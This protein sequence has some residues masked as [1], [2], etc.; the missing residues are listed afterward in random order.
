MWGSRRVRHMQCSGAAINVRVA[1]RWRRSVQIV[2]LVLQAAA[3]EWELR[4][5][6]R[7]L[8][9]P[10]RAHVYVQR[11]ADRHASLS[12]VQELCA[13]A[14][15]VGVV[16]Q[17]FRNF[18]F[19]QCAIIFTRLIDSSR[20]H[21]HIIDSCLALA[22]LICPESPPLPSPTQLRCASVYC[23]QSVRQGRVGCEG[24]TSAAWRCN[25]VH[26]MVLCATGSDSGRGSDSLCGT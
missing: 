13:H 11:S 21:A 2:M 12:C 14:W 10:G 8:V 9:I 17:R 19:P 6:V 26:S 3:R 15:D 7:T 20:R 5:R 25:V 18:P 22:A 24:G 4:G 1:R 16:V 23:R